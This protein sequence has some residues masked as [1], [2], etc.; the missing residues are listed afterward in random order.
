MR[1]TS[2]ADVPSLQDQAWFLS[3]IVLIERGV[4]DKLE[5]FLVVTLISLL[6]DEPHS[7]CPPAYIWLVQEIWTLKH[8]NFLYVSCLCVCISEGMIFL[9][10]RNTIESASKC[11]SNYAWVFAWFTWRHTLMPIKF[12][13]SRLLLHIFWVKINESD[14]SAFPLGVT[15]VSDKSPSDARQAR[16]SSTLI[17][18]SLSWIH[19]VGNFWVKIGCKY[20]ARLTGTMPREDSHNPQFSRN[21][22]MAFIDITL[23]IL[24]SSLVIWGEKVFQL[25][26]T[27]PK[28]SLSFF[29]I[30]IF[31]H[32]QF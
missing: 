2:S 15:N 10:L 4:S 7:F 21:V 3:I 24:T 1:D 30:I 19:A 31:K 12:Q 22:F 14:M 16:S 13:M 20:L 17:M 26:T 29:A 11:L 32:L 9:K 25:R 8:K 27:L 28:N 23:S 18:A 6:F 5:S